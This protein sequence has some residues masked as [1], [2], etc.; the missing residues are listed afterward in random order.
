V[1]K[2]KHPRSV[3][4]RQVATEKLRQV[5]RENLR[6]QVLVKKL[7]SVSDQQRRDLKDLTEI[8]LGAKR[9]VN[10]GD[11]VRCYALLSG[12]IKHPPSAAVNCKHEF[13]TRTVRICNHCLSQYL[14][15]TR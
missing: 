13:S 15:P 5:K 12:Y 9:A 2:S 4:P 3:S 7:M 6:L 8:I 10:N 11:M 1:A 14:A